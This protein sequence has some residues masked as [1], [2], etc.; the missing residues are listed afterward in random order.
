[1]PVEQLL[2]NFV[3][4][5][6]FP[7]CT[8]ELWYWIIKNFHFYSSGCSVAKKIVN[9][10]F[11]KVGLLISLLPTTENIVVT[12]IVCNYFVN[13]LSLVYVVFGPGEPQG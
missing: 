2:W 1:M 3:L 8:K 9:C 5:V 6:N 10:K 4:H 13:A 7:V 11:D 12:L